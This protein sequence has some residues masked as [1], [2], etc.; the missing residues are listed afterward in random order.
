MK[1]SFFS[2]LHDDIEVFIVIERGVISNY[3]C[4]ADPS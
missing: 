4:V 3:I 1:I 2:V